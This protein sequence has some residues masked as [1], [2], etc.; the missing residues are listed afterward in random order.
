M[1]QGNAITR[2]HVAAQGA[3]TALHCD[4]LVWPLDMVFIKFHSIAKTKE[5]AHG[6][7]PF[8]DP[9]IPHTHEYLLNTR[10]N[11]SKNVSSGRVRR[12]EA[13][14]KPLA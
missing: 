7:F 9:S 14:L 13:N 11:R 8:Q 12:E 10:R 3:Y 1:I 5:K 2:I 6:N 4:R